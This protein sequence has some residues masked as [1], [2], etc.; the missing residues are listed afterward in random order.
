NQPSLVQVLHLSNGSTVN[1]KLA[2]KAS[3]VSRLIANEGSLSG[4]VEEAFFI[5]L[6]RPPTEKETAAYTEIL[7]ELPEDELRVGV[8]D[9]FWALLTSREFLFQH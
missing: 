4:L 2:A 5:C 3:R 1:D 7:T 8:E 9:L 6:S